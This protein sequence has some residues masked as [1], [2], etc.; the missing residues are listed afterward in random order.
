MCKKCWNVVFL[1]DV[2]E[3]I[4]PE[5]KDQNKNKLNKTVYRLVA[6]KVILKIK[7]GVYLIPDTEDISLNSVDLVDKYYL[8]LLKKYI[9]KEVWSEYY[10]SWKKSLE[11]NLRNYSLSEKI[12]ITSRSTNK[13]VKVWNYEIIFKTISG[14]EFWKKINLY[15]KLTNYTNTLTI[16]WSEFKVANLELSILE[17]AIIWEADSGVWV[18]TINTAL[19]KYAQ[20]LKKE[21]FQD[22]A[23]YKYV[24]AFN[25]LK[26][27]SKNID[28][29]LYLCFLEIIKSN[30][31]LFIWEWGR[32]I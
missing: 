24:M 6:E 16:E 9:T 20:V 13:K 10:I 11:I 4:D 19:K 21:T 29:E 2:F 26:E 32:G 30:G 5:K 14:K 3:I 8:K 15:S 31:N 23:K 25:R 18:D 22:I 17:A 7:N 12:F 28:T 27:L 1:K